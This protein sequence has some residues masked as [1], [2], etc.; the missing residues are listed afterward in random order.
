MCVL[1]DWCI[2]GVHEEIGSLGFKTLVK[3]HNESCEI[4]LL[5]CSKLC[6]KRL[7]AFECLVLCFWKDQMHVCF[8]QFY[9]KICGTHLTNVPWGSTIWAWPISSWMYSNQ[10]KSYAQKNLILS[11]KTS[12]YWLNAFMLGCQTL[13]FNFCCVNVI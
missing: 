4:P 10:S 1:K 3:K 9:F 11:N 12:V 13:K 8:V 5:D 2:L 6:I 7:D